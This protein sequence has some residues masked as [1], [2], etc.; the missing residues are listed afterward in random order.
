VGQFIAVDGY[1]R[2]AWAL[3]LAESVAV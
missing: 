3:A 2:D 1:A